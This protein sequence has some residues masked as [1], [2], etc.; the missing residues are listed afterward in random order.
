MVKH[1]LGQAI[2]QSI[3]ILVILFGSQTFIP[4]EFCDNHPVYKDKVGGSYC[5]SPTRELVT[6]QEIEKKLGSENPGYLEDL[7][8]EWN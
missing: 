1:I 6:F 5:D 4:E 7:K 2:F 3:I 8:N